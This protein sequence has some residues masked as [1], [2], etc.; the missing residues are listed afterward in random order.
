M[1]SKTLHRREASL[2]VALV[3]VGSLAGCTTAGPD[4]QRPTMLAPTQ[5]S[6]WHGGSRVLAAPEPG[7]LFFL[8]LGSLLLVGRRRKAHAG[9]TP[10]A[11]RLR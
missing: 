8:V 6:D 1:R 11:P 10:A 7:S 2:A 3:V 4:F 9:R 5:M